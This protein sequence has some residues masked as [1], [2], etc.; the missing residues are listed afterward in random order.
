MLPDAGSMKKLFMSRFPRTAHLPYALGTLALLAA[1]SGGG[2]HGGSSFT[3]ATSSDV[4]TATAAIPSIAPSPEPSATNALSL[5]PPPSSPIPLPPTIVALRGRITEQGGSAFTL[6]LADGNHQRVHVAMSADTAIFGGMIRRGAY[7]EVAG[8][9]AG[10]HLLHADAVTVAPMPIQTTEATGVI[11]AQAPYG[12]ILDVDA[13]DPALPVVLSSGVALLGGA[14][15][16]GSTVTVTGAGSPTSCITARRV[17]TIAA[18]TAPPT[19]APP[20]STP[21]PPPI[22]Q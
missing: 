21:T 11:V 7:A 19:V 5:I 4:T 9:R 13:A 2:A 6:A 16:V 18:P 15:T 10:V 22:V 1:C 20:T 14:L 17:V 3:P 12:F 8:I